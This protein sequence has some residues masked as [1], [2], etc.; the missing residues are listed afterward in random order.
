MYLAC[1]MLRSAS[2]L[3]R[4]SESLPSACHKSFWI[5]GVNSFGVYVELENTVEGLVSVR[6]LP[7]DFYRYDESAYRL[8]GESTGR[9]FSLGQRLEVEVKKANKAMKYV[10]FILGE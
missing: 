10:D 1:R 8:I 6:D 4:A 2:L 5:S 9:C 7:E 3:T